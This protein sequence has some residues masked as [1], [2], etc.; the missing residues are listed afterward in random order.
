MD[1]VFRNAPKNGMLVITSTDDAALYGKAPDA[2]LR[3][4]GGYIAKTFYSKELAA[5][6]IIGAVV[7]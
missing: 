1:A 3:N 2:A 4:Y 6:L 7:R 5:R